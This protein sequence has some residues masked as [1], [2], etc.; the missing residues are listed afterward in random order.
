MHAPLR[1]LPSLAG[2]AL[3]AAAAVA[4]VGC[5]VTG[6]AAVTYGPPLV[7]ILT[8]LSETQFAQSELIEFGGVVRHDSDVY[9]DIEV[10][11]S[12]S[13]DGE[14]AVDAPDSD[15][16][17][18]LATNA[19][20]QGEH[21][22]T[23]TAVDRDGQDGDASIVVLVGPPVA[24]GPGAPTV[25]LIGPADGDSFV[26]GSAIHFVGTVTDEEQAWDTADV[27][28]TSSVDG[29]FWTGNPNGDG[30]VSV[31]YGDLGPGA[32][33]VTLTA[34]DEDGNFDSD[35][36]EFEITADGRPEVL[37]V[38]PAT[39][40]SRWLGET[41]LFEGQVSDDVTDNE[42]LL[43]TWTSSVDGTLASGGADSSGLTTVPVDTLLAGTHVITLTAVDAEAQEGTDTI[44]VEVVD[45]LDHDGDGD[46]QTENEGDCDDDNAAVYAGATEVC[47]AFDNDC[48]GSLNEDSLDSDEPNQ[49]DA[50]AIDLGEIDDQIGGPETLT[51]SGLTLHDGDDEDWYWFDGDDDNYDN[52]DITIHVSLP[53]TGS[54][55]VELYWLD[56]GLQLEDSATGNGTLTVEYEGEQFEDDEDDW[57]IRVYSTTWDPAACSAPYEIEITV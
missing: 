39:G 41:V 56:G 51:V 35:Q 42:D 6:L 12:S 52:V 5:Q 4:S 27:S 34:V 53:A 10:V 31:E 29:Q 45:P 37:I 8:P 22:I 9:D 18:S 24:G 28:L 14:L 11:W 15:G 48:D 7:S 26:V 2:L 33:I 49:T 30:T 3:V 32:H 44:T 19:L 1:L 55:T 13:L 20:S 25:I 47:D 40:S 54:Y 23:L 17:T 50:A 43:V 38:A 21:V 57:Y 16:A 36:V 46:G